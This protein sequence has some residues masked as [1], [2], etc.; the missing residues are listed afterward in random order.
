WEKMAPGQIAG[1]LQEAP[2]QK[3]RLKET[4]IQLC[5][6]ATRL[7]FSITEIDAWQN[8]KY[9]RAGQLIPQAI[10]QVMLPLTNQVDQFICYGDDMLNPL[11]FDRL[12]GAGKFKGLFNGFNTFRGGLGSDDDLGDKGD[13]ISTYI[14][15]RQA[16]RQKGFDTGPYY[17]LTDETTQTNA[18][19]GNLI[20]TLGTKAITEYSSL[21]AEYKYKQ[22]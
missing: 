8:N 5:Y 3:P 12:G 20:Y 10:R 9:V 13:I 21:M 2:I 14:R 22:G 16:L 15:G 18:E 11:A 6:L 19:Q 17:I 1:S 4:T 7:A